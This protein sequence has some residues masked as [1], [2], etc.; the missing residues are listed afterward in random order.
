MEPDF[1]TRLPVHVPRELKTGISTCAATVRRFGSRDVPGCDSA[2]G[3][4]S[5]E[6]HIPPVSRGVAP[7]VLIVGVPLPRTMQAKM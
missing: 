7:C 2:A 4:S 5:E 6:L 1:L 3:L